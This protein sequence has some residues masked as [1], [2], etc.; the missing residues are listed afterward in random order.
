MNLNELIAMVGWAVN[1]VLDLFLHA[2]W[3]GVAAVSG[4]W[5]AYWGIQGLYFV[6][7][8]RTGGHGLDF[9]ITKRTA[10]VCTLA[11]FLMD[12]LGHAYA[13]FRQD[14]PVTMGNLFQYGARDFHA[15]SWIVSGLVFVVV[16]AFAA[17]RLVDAVRQ[18]DA[19]P[20]AG[21]PATLEVAARRFGYAAALFL[22]VSSHLWWDRLLGPF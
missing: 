3:A 12:I 6:L 7:T 10:V 17:L 8:S 20:G 15:E 5:L 14:I 1:G 4:L 13:V 11:Q 21:M 2:A 19:T 9:T 18:A 16:G 22:S